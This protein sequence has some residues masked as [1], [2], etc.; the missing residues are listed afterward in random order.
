MAGDVDYFTDEEEA[1]DF[2]GFHGFAGEVGGVYAACGDFG[3]FVA[4]GAG[5]L[6][7]PRVQFPFECIQCNVG[8]GFRRVE[9]QPAFCEALR[10][11]FVERFFR[12]GGSAGAGFADFLR[13]FTA[14]G[15]ID[16][17]KLAF[18]PAAGGLQDCG[19]AEASM[20]E[21]HFF[22]EGGVA[23]RGDDFG[24]EAGEV[25]IAFAVGG[26]EKKRDKSRAGWD[27]VQTE[28]AGEI[29]AET[30][31]AHF[32]DG[33]SAG[34]DDESGRAIFGGIGANCEVSVATD[35]A[36]FGIYEDFYVG[37]AAFG[38][39]H[40]DD[41]GGGIVAEELAESFLVVGNSVFLDEG[42]EIG[43]RVARES[44]LGEVR[45][46]GEEVLRLGVKIREVAAAAAG[47]EDFLADF[48]G[49]FEEYYPAAALSGFDGAEESSGAAAQND[50][51]EVVHPD[52]S[53]SFLVGRKDL[54]ERPGPRMYT[55]CRNT[56]LQGACEERR[57]DRTMFIARMVAVV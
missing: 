14:G 17:Q 13:G 54:L 2:A 49:A 44:G 47:D 8:P 40:G 25:A 42:D 34:S 28:L 4:F 36:D 24:G 16:L 26:V 23:C 3:F 19:T 30:G 6:D 38:F 7:L 10:K 56:L 43:G 46:F 11:E 41:L 52:S 18:F 37:I 33:D 29:V 55:G 27:D 32:G 9:F 31:G 22:A 50:H 20:G 5:G 21:E 15:E 12:Y 48:F 53:R 39:E 57:K 1:G 35:F 51:I 45:I